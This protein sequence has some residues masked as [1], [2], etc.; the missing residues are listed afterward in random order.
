MHWNTP[1]SPRVKKNKNEQVKISSNDDCFFFDI[2]GIVYLHW[3]SEGQ[4]I[5]QHYYLEV[6]GNLRER[7]RKKRPEMWKEKSWI[8]HQDN[9]PAHSALSVKRFLAKHSIPVLEHPPYSPDLAPCDFYLFPK[10]KSPLKG[11]RFESEEAVKKKAARVLKELTKDDF[12]HCFQ[13][14][15]IRTE[16]CRDREGVYIEGDNK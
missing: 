5:N 16:R 9:A 11:T 14:W 3:V 4:T 13:Q 7:I 15:K 12:Q 6:L 1:T 8:F 10:V 2:H